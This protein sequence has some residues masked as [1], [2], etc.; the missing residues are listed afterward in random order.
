MGSIEIVTKQDLE[1]FKIELLAQIKL[2][3]EEARSEPPR[4]WLKTYQV[5][6]MLGNISAGTLQSMRNN[7]LLPYSILNGLA[8]YEYA[9]V[10]N[11]MDDMKISV[12]KR[13]N[14]KFG[15]NKL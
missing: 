8:L 2:L 3:I 4:R 12:K 7:G 6:E 1:Q 15:E 13:A 10:V 11:L 14:P 9:K 5:R